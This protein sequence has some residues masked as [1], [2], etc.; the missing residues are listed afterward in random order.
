MDVALK[1]EPGDQSNKWV[2]Y[3]V[4]ASNGKLYTGITTD[5]RRR[6][7]EH[8]T[9]PRGARF[10]RT[11]QPEAVVYIEP[12]PDRSQATRREMVI[13][14]MTRSRKL[15]LI[16]AQNPEALSIMTKESE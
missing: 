14:K 1:K 10:F 12:M 16:E 2:V 8:A 15:K 5:I 9:N 11:S 4:R 7:R 3:M 13:K 6:F